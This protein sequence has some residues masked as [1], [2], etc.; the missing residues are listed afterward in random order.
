M[1]PRSERENDF[2]KIL[3]QALRVAV[4]RL[5]AA[6]APDP[7]RDARRLMR[8]ALGQS[9]EAFAA[10]DP[11][12]ALPP[13][14]LARFAAAIDARAARQPVS[15]IIGERLFHGRRFRV[16]QDVLDP[17]P[18]SELLVD[19]ALAAVADSAAPARVLDLGTGSGCLLLSILAAAPDAVGLGLDQSAAALGVARENAARLGLQDRAGFAEWDWRE[20]WP[21]VEPSLGASRL[22]GGFNVL[23]CNPP[24]IPASTVDDLA[25]EVRL[26]E[27][28]AALTPADDPG[29][30]L[31]AYRRIS[32]LLDPI[33]APTGAALFEV[34]AGQA[35]AVAALLTA[36]GWRAETARD[37]DGRARVVSAVREAGAQAQAL[38][39]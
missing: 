21:P 27:P 36:K 38:S 23:V 19:L 31:S 24:Y 34:G 12:Q 6:E 22:T 20:P 33:L 32:A 11:G 4:I 5:R 10:A 17:R 8:F 2:P 14:A 35:E 39:V 3:G 9:A 25:P 7:V 18:E 29:D 28:R 16:T 37:L 30:G 15:Q 1:S 13:E 26:W